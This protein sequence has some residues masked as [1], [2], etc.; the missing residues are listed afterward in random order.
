MVKPTFELLR[1]CEKLRGCLHE[2]RHETHTGMSFIP[3]R[4]FISG[5]DLS[6]CCVYMI[7]GR[8]GTFVSGRHENVMSPFHTGMKSH[9]GMKMG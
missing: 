1:S 4:V 3:A 7:S 2:T 5:A 6:Y 9:A 8:Y